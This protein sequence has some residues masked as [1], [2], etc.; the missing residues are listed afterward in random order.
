MYAAEISRDLA[1]RDALT[2]DLVTWRQACDAD[3]GCAEFNIDPVVVSQLTVTALD[4]KLEADVTEAEVQSF[5]QTVAPRLGAT[6]SAVTGVPETSFG[7]VVIETLAPSA[8]PPAATPIKDGGGGGG[9]PI[10][11]VAGGAAGGVVLLVTASAIFYFCRRNK[12]GQRTQAPTKSG[13]AKSGAKAS[14]RKRRARGGGPGGGPKS[15]ALPEGW[16]E[17]KD[18]EGHT[19]YHN[20]LTRETSWSRPRAA[21]KH[22]KNTDYGRSDVGDVGPPRTS[23]V[24]TAGFV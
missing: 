20:E 11:A 13:I 2:C 5:R 4:L 14:E 17:C 19:F 7:A 9:L 23:V 1:P 21:P 18:D 6:A 16:E 3:P 10:A 22:S 8:S 24:R 15:R 12:Q